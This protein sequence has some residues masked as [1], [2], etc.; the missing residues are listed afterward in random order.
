MDR[1]GDLWE[2]PCG[3]NRYAQL[4]QSQQKNPG[5]G[6]KLDSE[7][8]LL[9]NNNGNISQVQLFKVKLIKYF[10][11]M[12]F[13][14]CTSYILSAQELH[15]ATILNSPDLQLFHQGRKFDWTQLCV[16]FPQLRR[17]EIPVTCLA[18]FCWVGLEPQTINKYLCQLWVK[19]SEVSFFFC[20]AYQSLYD[21]LTIEYRVYSICHVI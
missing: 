15:V 11:K 9:S 13:P 16:L 14:G 19:Q 4:V 20:R 3:A 2:G 6:Q 12:Q 7:G 10:L 8:K 18:Q 17:V 21:V 5:I 1:D